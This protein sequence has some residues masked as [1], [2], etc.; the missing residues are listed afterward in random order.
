MTKQ[1]IKNVKTW[2]HSIPKT[3]Q[4]ISSLEIATKDLK[5]KLENPLPDKKEQ[6]FRDSLAFLKDNLK[7]HRRKVEQYRD[8]LEFLKQE[9]QWGYIAEEIIRKKYYD[10]VR[11]DRVVYVKGLHISEAWFYKLHR[12][13][14]KLF[15]DVLPDVFEVRQNE[16]PAGGPGKN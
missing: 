1:D 3:E 13:G 4:A 14:L 10:R 11:P 7:A 8:T 2:L 12:R 16:N 9:P 15:F 5:V 6:Y